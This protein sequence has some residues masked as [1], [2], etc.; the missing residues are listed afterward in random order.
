M[1]KIIAVFLCAVLCLMPLCGCGK[2]EQP[3]SPPGAVDIDVTEAMYVT[4]IN[5]LY[6]NYQSYLGKV[7][8][9]QGMYASEDMTGY[10]GGIYHY[11]YRVGPGC[12]G[13]DGTMCGFEFTWDSGYPEPNDWIEVTGV[14]GSY[15]END[16]EYLTLDASEVRV[17]DERGAEVVSQ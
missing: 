11:V 7:V 15:T 6:T 2:D 14:L 10:G 1:K 9:I 17:L 13:N 16:C 3:S 8:R 4:Y 12:C 5:E